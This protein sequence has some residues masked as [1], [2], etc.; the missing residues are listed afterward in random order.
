MFYPGLKKIASEKWENA[1]RESA[2]LE[3]L[4]F[5]PSVHG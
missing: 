3:A 1:N 5:I 2:Y 4:I